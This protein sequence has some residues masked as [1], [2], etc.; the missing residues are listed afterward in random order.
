MFVLTAAALGLG[1]IMY[2]GAH[3]V[4]PLSSH[5]NTFTDVNIVEETVASKGLFKRG[6]KVVKVEK[7]VEPIVES[8]PPPPPKTKWFKRKPK[9][10]KLDSDKKV[11]VDER[12]LYIGKK[13]GFFT[14]KYRGVKK[15]TVNKYDNAK[16]TAS[17]AMTIIK[18]VVAFV[19][20]GLV[21]AA[22]GV[23]IWLFK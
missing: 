23:M 8:P 12:D 17:T 16:N 7:K 22:L 18:I 11:K 5:Y 6:A 19:I 1:Y 21:G 14:R 3:V 20:L 10:V 15:N 9:E 2:Q 4:S 13:P